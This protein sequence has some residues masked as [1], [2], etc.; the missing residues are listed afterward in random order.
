MSQEDTDRLLDFFKAL[1]DKTRLKI[2]GI[3]AQREATTEDLAGILQ[4]SA[5]TVSHH[6]SKLAKAGLVKARAE[7]YY[8][9]YTLDPSQLETMAKSLLGT[10]A[11]ASV[12]AAE[13]EAYDKK[14]LRDFTSKDG[15]F[16][17]IPTQRKKRSVLLHHIAVSFKPGT[18]Y[19]EKKVNEIL[20][21]FHDDTATLRRE[22]IA[23]KLLM[24]DSGTYWRKE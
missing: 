3:L 6:L 2:V 18:R 19:S 24:R 1:A 13:L 7:S 21:R 4:L 8:S 11:V 5:G 10:E 14:L 22:L 15:K 16:K 17:S 20:R 12:P 23:E 9:I